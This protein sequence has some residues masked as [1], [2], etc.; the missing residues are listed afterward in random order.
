VRPTARPPWQEPRWVLQ[1]DCPA[2]WS[3]WLQRCE[4]G[5]FH[6]P[7]GLEFA[8]PSAEPVFA[9]LLRGD[10]LVG[11]AAGVRSR[12][13]L[14][15]RPRHYYFPTLPALVDRL[16]TDAVVADLARTLRSHGAGDVV[17]DSFDAR[18]EPASA[19]PETTVRQEYL[20]SLETPVSEHVGRWRRD[21]R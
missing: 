3:A 1:R 16:Q 18:W 9:Q 13:R 7:L 17:F 2:D 21:H 5:F 12:C 15:F 10:E 6:S 4:G 11:V 8:A 14:S 19:V 20:V